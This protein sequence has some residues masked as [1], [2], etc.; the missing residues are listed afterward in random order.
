MRK[1]IAITHVT[2]DG[3][4]QAPGGPEEDPRGGFTHGGWAMLYGDEAAGEVMGKIMSGEFDLLLGRR[5]YEIFAAYW[6]YAGDNFIAKAFNKAAKFV[7][8]RSLKKFDWVNSQH[9][10]GDA[11]DEIR[12]LK[13]SDGPELHIW[14]SSELLQTLIAT[15]LVDEFRVWVYPVVLGKGKRLFETGVPPRGLTLVESRSTTKGVLFNTYRPTGPLPRES[16]A[17]ENP[18]EAELARRRKLAAE[19]AQHHHRK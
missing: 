7:V 11:V 18:S 6:P 1:I 8:T 14:G 16:R 5:T 9:I 3:V 12:R 15:D 13:A 2:L 19:E 10:G 17:P 4:M